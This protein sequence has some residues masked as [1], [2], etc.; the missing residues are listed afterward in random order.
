[1]RRKRHGEDDPLRGDHGASRPPQVSGS[2]RFEG[3]ELVGKSSHKIAGMGDRL[4]P[5]GPPALPVA[6]ESTSTCGWSRA[7]PAAAGGTSRA[8]ACRHTFAAEWQ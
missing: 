1:M 6:F 8:V 2:V 4:R 7:G 3:K 5:A